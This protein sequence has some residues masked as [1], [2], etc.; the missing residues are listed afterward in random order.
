MQFK[1]LWKY[2]TTLRLK[3]R[4]LKPSQV[5]G[6]QNGRNSQY[7]RNKPCKSIDF[8]LKRSLNQV[9]LKWMLHK[10]YYLPI[11]QSVLG[12]FVLPVE[13]NLHNIVLVCLF[14]KISIFHTW[15]MPRFCNYKAVGNCE[16]R[17]KAIGI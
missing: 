9:P 5:R 14:C 12:V 1:L 7:I 6:T 13:I 3:F 10:I 2:E 8:I 17:R 11:T 16:A 15:I 4:K